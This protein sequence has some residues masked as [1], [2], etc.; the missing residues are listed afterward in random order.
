MKSLLHLQLIA[1]AASG[2][3]KD[4]LTANEPNAHA[5]THVQAPAATHANDDGASMASSEV[6]GIARLLDL[7]PELK[8]DIRAHLSR[9]EDRRSEDDQASVVSAGSSTF[10]AYEKTHTGSARHHAAGQV[11]QRTKRLDDS[12]GTPIHPRRDTVYR[13][14][15]AQTNFSA[16]RPIQIRDPKLAIENFDGKEVYPGL[17]SG[18][19]TWG[20]RFLRQ[21]NIAEDLSGCMWNDEIKMDVLRRHLTGKVGQHFHSQVDIWY[22][23]N[24]QVWCSMDRMNTKFGPRISKSQAFK[25]FSSKKKNVS[26]NDHMLYLMALSDAIRGAHDQLLESIAKFASPSSE[27]QSVLLARFNPQRED[28]IRQ[29][30]ELLHFAQLNDPTV[31]LGNKPSVATVKTTG[32]GRY[33]NNSERQRKKPDACFKCGKKGP[34]KRDCKSEATKDFTLAVV[35]GIDATYHWILDRG[36]SRHLVTTSSQL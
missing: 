31:R 32:N 1:K 21:I 4:I 27:F 11:H 20:K 2:L 14:V 17:G 28:Y 35:R 24:P 33:K 13:P 15:P 12:Q 7:V 19:G 10:R 16:Q 29:V 26:W 30:E 22:N 5:E 6:D 3:C 23:E 18:F 9:I 8:S 25:F 34:Y 36:S